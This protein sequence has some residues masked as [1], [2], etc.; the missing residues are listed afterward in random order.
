[1]SLVYETVG[2][3]SA[4][5]GEGSTVNRPWRVFEMTVTPAKPRAYPSRHQS[6]FEASP[7]RAR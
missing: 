2:S 1:V 4:F 6:P 5:R 3:N 7:L